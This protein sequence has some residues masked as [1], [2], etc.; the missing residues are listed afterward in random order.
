MN[1][2]T[3]HLLIHKRYSVKH[4][5][6][7]SFRDQWNHFLKFQNSLSN[8][9]PFIY[10]FSLQTVSWDPRILC[11]TEA[12]YFIFSIPQHCLSV[13]LC[14]LNPDSCSSTGDLCLCWLGMINFDK[15]KSLA[16]IFMVP[17]FNNFF[18]NY[19]WNDVYNL[20]F[21]F[22]SPNTHFLCVRHSD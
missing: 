16:F 5:W 2:V 3:F 8:Q 17:E 1:K 14:I 10:L 6:M 11:S 18:L 21:T 19:F 7:F 13:C 4:F 9:Q 20:D 15:I 22:W 12:A